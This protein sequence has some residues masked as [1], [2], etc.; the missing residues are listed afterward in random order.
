MIP[1]TLFQPEHEEFRK[2]VRRFFQEEIVPEHD[3]WEEQNHVDR[4]IW[5]RAGELGLLCMS[6]PEEYGGAG[7]DRL[8]NVI[9]MEEQARVGATGVG[10]SLHTDIVANYINNLGTP[11]QK[12]QWLPKMAR[13]EIVTAIAMSEP[14]VG[15]DLQNIKTRAVDMGDHWLVT[16]SKT[17]ITNGL[18]SDL[19]VV[20]VKTDPPESDKGARSVSLML[21]ET[22]SPGFS[23]GKPLKKVGMKAQDTCELFLQNVKV[24]K[25]NV[26]GG[27]G[28]GFIALMQELPWERMTIALGSV[29]AAEATLEQTIEYTRNRK[30]MGQSVASYQNSRFKLA[31]MKTE[32]SFGQVYV[33]R[34]LELNLKGQLSPEDAAAAKYWCTDLYCRVVDQCVQLHGGY[35]YMLEYPVARAYVD[36]RPTRIFG[37]SN[38]IMKE[39]IARSMAI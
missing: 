17:F 24:P 36:C 29:A 30:V 6:M 4:A 2:N 27:V 14:A 11:E 20:A 33:D 21:I 39:L 10:F 38:E 12:S 5:N 16:G 32:I 19:A 9:M 34:C 23:K 3:A 35:G 22:A 25:E 7:A 37:G 1:R 8:Y 13:G 15:T 26:L 18:L 31:E 28:K